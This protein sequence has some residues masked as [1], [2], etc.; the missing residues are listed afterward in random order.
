MEHSSTPCNTLHVEGSFE[1]DA[2]LVSSNQPRVEHR[3]YTSSWAHQQS[4][5]Y[6]SSSGSLL[7][8]KQQSCWPPRAEGT[9]RN[10]VGCC[11]LC[12]PSSDALA[13][14]KL[15]GRQRGQTWGRIPCYLLYYLLAF[16]ML[17][18]STASKRNPP[19]AAAAGPPA[20]SSQLEGTEPFLEVTGLVHGTGFGLASSFHSQVSI[21]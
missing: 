16:S 8:P 12:S 4:Q 21:A 7:C 9:S 5:G 19:A 11:F 13:G 20:D 1:L 14:G 15:S 17:Q 10:H 3:G 6:T 2:G 18:P